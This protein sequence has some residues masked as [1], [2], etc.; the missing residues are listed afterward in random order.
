MRFSGAGSLRFGLIVLVLSTLSNWIFLAV[1]SVLFFFLN[2]NWTLEM[3]TGFVVR[4]GINGFCIGLF[5]R[6]YK[7]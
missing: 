1:C 2:P 5:V 3:S 6:G 7:N 4:F